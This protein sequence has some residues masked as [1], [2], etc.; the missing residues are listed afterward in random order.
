M[1]EQD[2]LRFIAGEASIRDQYNLHLI[3][4]NI[5]DSCRNIIVKNIGTLK[6]LP[7]ELGNT[8]ANIYYKLCLLLKIKRDPGWF[9]KYNESFENEDPLDNMA[10][11]IFSYNKLKADIIS[12]PNFIASL[13]SRKNEDREKYNYWVDYVIDC[14]KY[15]IENINYKTIEQRMNERKKIRQI[16]EI[17]NL[18]DLI[19]T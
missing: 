19:N 5:L 10:K 1:K 11:F 15:D 7:Y 9:P 13:R 8:V 12:I 6:D 2:I 16:Q 4:Q 3:D 14:L 18:V 17:P